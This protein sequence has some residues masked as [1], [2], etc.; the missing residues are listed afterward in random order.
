M[1]DMVENNYVRF[2]GSGL[3]IKCKKLICITDENSDGIEIDPS[4]LSE[5]NWLSINGFSYLKESNSYEVMDANQ[6]K[7]VERLYNSPEFFTYTE[8]IFEEMKNLNATK[9]ELAL[10]ADN[11]VING[12]VNKRD[13]KSVALA[14]LQ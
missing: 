13:P 2:M 5:C 12:L 9:E 14:I 1:S 11:T 8:S 3:S 6:W 4:T 10:L 7:E